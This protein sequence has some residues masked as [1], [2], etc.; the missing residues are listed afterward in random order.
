MTGDGGLF[1][2]IAARVDAAAPSPA[3][4]AAD[5][6]DLDDR[7]RA[8]MQVL[9]RHGNLS[10]DAL[11]QHLGWTVD[12]AAEVA[13]LLVGREAVVVDD[14]SVSVATW[15]SR[16]RSPGGIWSRLGDL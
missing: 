5:L 2:R 6:L 10:L 16:R 9:L 14:S 1:G 15:Q 13:D 7:E 12:Q 11:A 4:S 8:A 3:F